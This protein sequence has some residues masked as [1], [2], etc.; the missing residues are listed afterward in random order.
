MQAVQTPGSVRETR[1]LVPLWR[2][3]ST[4]HRQRISGASCSRLI[5]ACRSAPSIGWR[6]RTG[7]TPLGA[8]LVARRP[9]R[10]VNMLALVSTERVG[11]AQPP[12]PAKPEFCIVA[13][14]A[15]RLRLTLWSPT[16]PEQESLSGA[17]RAATRLWFE[18][19]EVSDR[20][21]ARLA[22]PLVSGLS[23]GCLCPT[24]L[25]HR[26]A[27]RPASWLVRLEQRCSTVITDES[28]L[29]ESNRPPRPHQAAIWASGSFA[30]ALVRSVLARAWK[31]SWSSCRLAA[32]PGGGRRLRR[33]MARCRPAG[34][35]CAGAACAL[36]ISRW[37][38]LSRVRMRTSVATKPS[39]AIAAPPRNAVWNPSVSACGT[40]AP[41]ARAL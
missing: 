40:L 15:P 16:A 14:P 30:V 29:R 3:S 23:R 24:A 31:L 41:V 10:I 19:A 39:A 13:R 32:S 26:A 5:A 18:F 21:R 28:D 11:S 9:G 25:R 7:T 20:R 34:A 27:T 37:A 6:P 38:R 4:A 12:A 33:A 36:A 2:P 22:D 17:D 35:H 1:T 8:R